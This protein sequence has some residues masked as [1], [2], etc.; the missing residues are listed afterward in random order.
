MGRRQNFCNHVISEE[1]KNIEKVS[2]LPCAT[3][4]SELRWKEKFLGGA[5]DGAPFLFGELRRQKRL[6]VESEILK[7]QRVRRVGRGRA[8]KL[9]AAVGAKG[10]V[11]RGPLGVRGVAGRQ[12]RNHRE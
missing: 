11:L 12:V 10:L 4:Y 9:F 1:K 3:W 2:H 8:E 7:P 6:T 5:L